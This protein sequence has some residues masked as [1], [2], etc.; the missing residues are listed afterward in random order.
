MKRKKANLG[1]IKNSI[2]D[3]IVQL[4]RP[5][6]S[7]SAPSAIQQHLGA[8]R[9]WQQGSLSGFLIAYFG[10]SKMDMPL[11]PTAYKCRLKQRIF[12]PE[13]IQTTRI[14]YI[15]GNEEFTT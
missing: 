3:K 7:C 2:F 12:R 6:N 14:K 8:V 9:L 15:I 4:Q 10:K 13:L 11:S 5:W 1:H